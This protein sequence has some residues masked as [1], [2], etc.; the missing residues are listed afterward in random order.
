M[1]CYCDFDDQPTVYSA[2]IRRSRKPYSCSECDGAILPGDQY[3]RAFM[4]FEGYP[5]TYR[6]CEPC[7]NLRTWVRNNVP[8]LCW[9]HEGGDQSM[10]EAIEEATFRAPDETRGLWFGFLRR[11]VERERFH[12]SRRSAP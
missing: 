7:V 9:L 1:T 2:T 4:V 12:K 8:C 5:S 3:E 11:K 6:T 10:A